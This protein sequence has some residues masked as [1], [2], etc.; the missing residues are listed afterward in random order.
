MSVEVIEI[1]ESYLDEHY[2]YAPQHRGYP[3]YIVLARTSPGEP[4]IHFNGHYDV[5]PPG[6]SWSRDP[7]KPVIENGKLYGRGATDMKG[8]IASLIAALRRTLSEGE[9]PRPVELAFVPDEESGGIETRYL[10]EELGVRPR[11]VLIAEPTTSGLLG[12]RHKGMIRE[13]IKVIGKQGHASRPWKA[14]NAFEKACLLVSKLLGEF[15]PQL[16]RVRSSYPFLEEEAHYTTIAL[17]GYA[18]SSSMKDNVIP[19]EFVSSFDIRTIPEQNNTELFEEFREYL[20]RVATELQVGI[21][22]VKLIDI[23]AAFTPLDSPLI[24]FVKSVAMRVLGYEPRIYVNTG[25]FDLVF[26]RRYGSHVIAY[27]PGASGQAHAIDEYTYIN[28]IEVFVELYSEMIK[29]LSELR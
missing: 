15:V 27:G 24:G 13:L 4:A 3:R 21:D 7:F 22:I 9:L 6:S 5:V 11:Y 17:G 2:P 29:R 16:Q 28:E 14:V 25:R 12:I 1:S 23:P 20:Q 10:V 18:T 26:Y 19:N 8:G